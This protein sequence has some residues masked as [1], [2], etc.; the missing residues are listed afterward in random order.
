MCVV[1]TPVVIYTYSFNF[2]FHGSRKEE[3]K[4]H[5]IFESEKGFFFDS[6]YFFAECGINS[7]NLHIAHNTHIENIQSLQHYG[8]GWLPLFSSSGK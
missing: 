6:F 7:I 8:I 5:K 4:I 3:E 1:Y 2:R